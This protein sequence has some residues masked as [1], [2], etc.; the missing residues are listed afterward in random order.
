MF[1]EFE[2]SSLM[3]RPDLPHIAESINSTLREERLRREKFRDELTP[4][5]KAEFIGGEVVMHSPG[6]GKGTCVLLI[7][8]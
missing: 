6:Q 1:E 7:T 4:S 2:L 8:W 5:V 3:S